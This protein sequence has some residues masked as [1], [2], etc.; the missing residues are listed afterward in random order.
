VF[1]DFKYALRQFSKNPVFTAVVVLSLAFGIGANTA[2]F[3]LVDALILKSLP[4]KDPESLVLFQWV[5][6]REGGQPLAISGGQFGEK[7]TDPTTG[8]KIQQSFSLRTF[9]GFRDEHAM[10]AEV[11]AVG[12]MDEINLN[13]DNL[14][15]KG[16]SGQLVSGNY[17]RALG[18]PA[19][20]GRTLLPEDDRPGAA[21]VAVLSYLY[22]HR[23]FA[24]DPAVIGKT[25]SVN[26][27]AV[28]I[29]GV[30]PAGFV[31]TLL[32]AWP[33]DITLPLALAPQVRADGADLN[34]PGSW[35]LNLMGRLKPG[36][37]AEQAQASLQGSFQESARGGISHPDDP[38]R[39]R[40]SPGGKGRT[41]ADLRYNAK[42]LAPLVGMV[43]LV[44]LTACANAANLLLARGASRRQE[45]AVRLALGAS[46]GRIIRQ[47]LMES[48]L[49]AL[50]AAAMGLLVSHW[51]LG[52]LSTLVSS[53]ERTIFDQLTLD[54]RVLG[55]TMVST[56]LTGIGFGLAPALRATRLNLNAEFQ[57]GMRTL[58]RG[59]RTRLNKALL[60]AQV[61]LAVVLLV[62][63]G[64]F[65]QTE[66]NLQAVNLG[67]NDTHLL[68]FSLNGAPLGYPKAQFARL[69]GNVAERITAVP[70]V[71]SVTFSG[72]PLV[73]F[74]GGER[75]NFSV[76]GIS[77]PVGRPNQV[78]WNQVGQNFFQTY[79]MPLL[80]GRGIIAA[81]DASSLG[82]A[83]INQTLA[84]KYFANENPI[85][86]TIDLQGSRVIVGVVHDA[87]ETHLRAPIPPT[88]FI[89]FS[90]SPL[91]QAHFAVRTAG[92][93]RAMI[94]AV[95]NA[96][97]EMDRNLPL[98][99]ARTGEEQMQ[100]TL[101]GERICESVAVAL[102]VLAL[103]LVCVGLYGLMSYTVLRRTGEIGLRM[104]LGAFPGRVL[105]MVLR[106]S[107]ML[108]GMG[109]VLGLTTAAGVTRLISASFYGLSASDPATYAG[110][111]MLLVVVA[112]LA[113]LIP[114]RSAAR[115]DPVIALRAE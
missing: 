97:A 61:G 30:T 48:L 22:W 26:R 75:S 16:L 3:A 113:C 98:G 100:W 29:V 104:A 25:L 68:L 23:R 51:G 40:L 77:A 13:V 67:F 108:V 64:L 17:Y 11:F 94:G 93:P 21:P 110:V 99:N 112:A 41:E 53:A 106:E 34:K 82:I 58:G 36:V 47:L 20:R 32:S 60:I 50:A 12:R 89:P 83:V 5:P 35:W 86:R 107:L 2:I 55:F 115:I 78:T 44:L 9:E 10:L 70:G 43:G 111:T 74:N 85:G 71:R 92:A 24:D 63:A 18:V 7:D 6:G 109:V 46:R 101:E 54:W 45:I 76:A 84:R 114:A 42:T 91:G 96:V 14:A 66:S 56:L 49:L 37:T 73:S 39:L 72:W 80:L 79:E 88:V 102:G 27:V 33:A 62:V 65:A 31:G 81:D 8:Q 69:H 57:G 19:L 28:T 59:A 87:K 90:Q 15:E 52:L 105:W 1:F 38:P 4:V 103:L 95:R